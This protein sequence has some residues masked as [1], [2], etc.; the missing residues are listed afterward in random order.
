M[1][2]Y[3]EQKYIHDNFFDLLDFI[4]VADAMKKVMQIAVWPSYLYPDRQ[5]TY[6]QRQCQC[7][8]IVDSDSGT[9][10]LRLLSMPI[11]SIKNQIYVALAHP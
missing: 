11:F 3:R 5:Q 9:K 4:Y 7:N 6:Y 8:N 10:L 1:N 2:V